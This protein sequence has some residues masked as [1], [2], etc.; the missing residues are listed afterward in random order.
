MDVLLPDVSQLIR[1]IL[2]QKED[3]ACGHGD[4]KGWRFSL[5]SEAPFSLSNDE[6]VFVRNPPR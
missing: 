3:D 1:L 2:W 5:V 6:I 4:G